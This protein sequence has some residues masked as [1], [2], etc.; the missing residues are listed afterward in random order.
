MK[1]AEDFRTSMKRKDI[2]EKEEKMRRV[3]E[4]QFI[5]VTLW[6][7]ERAALD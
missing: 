3:T 7:R 2:A 4:E 6:D 5:L 1:S